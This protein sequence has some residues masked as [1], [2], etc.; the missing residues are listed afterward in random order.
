ML[1]LPVVEILHLKKFYKELCQPENHSTIDF[2][3]SLSPTLVILNV[4]IQFF[5][6]PAGPLLWLM[7]IL[8]VEGNLRKKETGG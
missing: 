6:A 4:N 3:I 2:F 7:L 8:G 1:I 5:S